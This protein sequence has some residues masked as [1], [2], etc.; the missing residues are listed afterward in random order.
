VAD[1]D[2]RYIDQAVATAKRRNPA[3][4]ASVFDFVRD[5][6]VR[7]FD[8]ATEAQWADHCNFRM[9]FQQLT[10]PVMAKGL[11]DTA[12]YID[13]RLTS[14]NEV[15]GD[16]TIFGTSAAE[17]HR[18]NSERLRHWPRAMLTSSTH[19]TKRSEDLRARIDV[20]S[21]IPREWRAA[22]NRWA[23]LNRRHKTKVE[24]VLAPDRNDEYL[25]YQTLL[26][27]WPFDLDRPDDELIGRIDAYMLKAIHE[28]QV[29]TSWINPNTAYDEAMSAFVRATLKP[30][31][32][33]PFLDDFAPF[34]QRIAEVGIVNSL[35]QQLLKLTSPGIP[36][37]YQGAE[38]W[39]LSL[40]DPDN[41]RPV[42]YTLRRRFL[43]DLQRRK[44]SHRLAADLWT[45]RSDGALKLYVTQRALT[46]RQAYCD[47]FT[48]GEYIPLE[49]IGG[50]SEHI[51]TFARRFAD[52]EL[53]V[54]VPCLVASLLK[55][56]SLGP[57]AWEDTRILLPGIPPG[58]RYRN[59]LTNEI[60][61]SSR[62][63][64]VVALAVADL[65]A[66]LPVA[67]LVRD[68]SGER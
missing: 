67:L 36:D 51:C 18:Q 65:F 44:P 9:K 16:P 34:R 62:E 8:E 48:R 35:A 32:T 25:F 29:H 66:T 41:R 39:D 60:V 42:D 52:R 15:G 38:I 23:R 63:S 59:A 17:F 7:S 11:E 54:A 58:T 37:L 13:N 47:P 68:D 28:A 49:T 33:N 50:Q 24:G 31:G 19:D 55:G 3:F 1:R 21:E 12:F 20:L 27:A 6:L 53:V 61:T 57:E 56:D 4:E 64:D 22:I 2:R 26:G 10:G 14:L 46:L 45:R 43:R 30:K 5:V 40:V